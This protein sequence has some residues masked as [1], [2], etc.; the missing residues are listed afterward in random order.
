MNIKHLFLVFILFITKLSI[1]QQPLPDFKV[2]FLGGNKASISWFNNFEN[3]KQISIQKSYDSTKFF[4]TIFTTQS[5]ELP[6][7]GYVDNNYLPQIKTW[8]RIFYVTDTLGS[9]FFTKS[10]TPKLNTSKL[11]SPNTTEPPQ[12]VRI[13]TE[14]NPPKTVKDSLKYIPFVK[15]IEIKINVYY[16]KTDSLIATFNTVDFLNFK[17]SI[18]LKTKDTLYSPKTYEYILKPYVPVIIWKPSTYVFTSKKGVIEINLPKYKNHVYKLI[19]FDNSGKELFKIKHILLEK[20]L[21]EKS[22]FLQAGWYKFELYEDDKLKEK[23]KF[24]VE[25]D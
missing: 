15:P 22:N 16:K 13:P 3:C 11:N 10:Q 25:K 20:I 6:A 17:D 14:L 12:I 2:S 18:A 24:L 23:N 1:A 7:N 8:Y 5:P 21:L 4:Q 19:V 9:F